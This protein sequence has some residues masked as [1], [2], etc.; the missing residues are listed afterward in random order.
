MS[1]H[2]S[3]ARRILTV[4]T[5]TFFLSFDSSM[6]FSLVP[7]AAAQAAEND[8]SQ[9]NSGRDTRRVS[10]HSQRAGALFQDIQEAIEQENYDNAVA[11]LNEILDDRKR[12]KGVDVAV[13]L[14][15]RGYTY[16]QDGRL[17]SALNDFEKA[18]VDSALPDWDVLPLRFTIAQLY[19]ADGRVTEAIK[20]LELWFVDAEAPSASAYFFAAQAYAQG[21]EWAKA[22]RNAEE[23]LKKMD[24]NEPRES[25]YRIATI[26]YFQNQRYSRAAPMLETMIS[27]WPDKKEYYGQLSAVYT[28]LGRDDD[29]FAVQAMAYD[30]HLDLNANELMRLGQLYRVYEFPFEA[31]KIFERGIDEGKLKRNK[32][33]CEE[34]GNAYFQAR[35]MKK[36]MVPLECAANASEDGENWLKLCQVHMQQDAWSRAESACRSAIAKGGLQ[37]YAGLA[38]QLLGIALYEQG[39]RDDAISVFETCLAIE[40]SS[41]FCVRR[42]SLAQVELKRERLEQQRAEA[43][44]DAEE[45]RKA[46]RERQIK[47]M[48]EDAKRLK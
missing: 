23:G 28:E 26:I 14:K 3:F 11:L 22:E 29:A 35:E 41:D 13:A 40:E 1:Q 25:W 9:S 19:L 15:M 46:E 6:E 2:Q 16:A 31:A 12:F 42:K 5:I 38:H 24:L 48:E 30:N 20:N 45:E 21:D 8:R 32:M 37:E 27:L 4:L 33:N 43:S 36:A 39:K 7:Q 10:A 44:A 47:Q 34:L 17:D 18:I